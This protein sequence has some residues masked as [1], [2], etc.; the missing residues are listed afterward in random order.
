[1][2]RIGIMGGT[3]DPIH[4]GHLAT[5]EAVRESLNLQKIIFIPAANPPHK[6]EKK[7]ASSKHRLN[8][9]ELATKSN[10]FFEVS[11]MEIERQGLSYSLLTINELREKIEAEFFFITGADA[12]NE[13]ATWYRAKELLARCNFVVA[14]RGGSS[15]NFKPLEEF[16]G[17][18]AREKIHEIPTPALEISSTEIREKIALGK[19]IRYLVPDEIVEYIAREGLYR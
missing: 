2:A 3:F 16:F 18:I 11:A 4:L 17:A 13:L 6:T 5:A 12:V 14:T 1:M 10:P 8:M 7:I 15:L 19:S 9:V